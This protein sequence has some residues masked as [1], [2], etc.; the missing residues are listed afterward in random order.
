MFFLK[1]L[2]NPQSIAPNTEKLVDLITEIVEPD[3]RGNVQ[4]NLN[5]QT[6][7]IGT[8]SLKKITKKQKKIKSKTLTRKEYAKLGLFT[9][10]TAAIKYQDLLAL[11]ELWKQYMH[12]HL[13]LT[14]GIVPKWDSQSY[15]N[16]SKLLVKSDFHGAQIK[17]SRSRCPSFVGASGIVAMD[18]K[19]TFKIVGKDNKLRSKLK[20]CFLQKT[21]LTF[22][23]IFLC[24]DTKARFCVSNS[25]GQLGIYDFR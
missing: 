11:H 23:P 24:S 4:I 21:R 13:D 10:P 18:T 22:F 25:S 1:V 3:L 15:E 17:V 12:D 9:L 16:F 8:K 14:D 5:H 7:L 2:A 6:N 20:Q 19:N